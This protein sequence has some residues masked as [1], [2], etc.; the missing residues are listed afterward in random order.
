[1]YFNLILA[2]SLLPEQASEWAFKVDHVFLIVTIIC[3][4][5]FVLVEGALV[6]LVFKYRR[7][8]N[9]EDKKTPFITHNT[10]LEVI[11]AIIPTLVMFVLFYYGATT[12]YQM[13][14]MPKEYRQIDVT[15]RQWSWKF[16]YPNGVTTNTQS[17]CTNAEFKN[18]LDCEVKGFS[19]KAG[20]PLVVPINQKVVLRMRSKDVI[21]S[22]YV[23]AFRVKQDVVPGITSKLWFTANRIGT[24]DIFCAEYCGL[25][26]SGMI[27]K[28]IVKLADEYES[29]LVAAKE[30]QEK[31]AALAQNPEQMAALGKELFSIKKGCVACHRL[32][33]KRLVG[34]PLNG[35]FGKTRSFMD[36]STVTADENY[37]SESIMDPAAKIV[38]ES[39]P[40]PPM[41]AQD[42]NENEVKAIVEFLKGCRDINC[43]G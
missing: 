8:K 25:D 11:W 4:I 39:P 17:A 16:T 29:W 5:S 19:W 20:E 9:E 35:I 33:G 13:R 7:K 15:G 37:L 18:Q 42:V 43:G 22:F 3:A 34:P 1:M 14:T 26:H 41:N 40:Y 36:G 23:P 10:R 21:H 24:Y 2:L 6:F 31:M 12:Y 27:G 30:E 32:D 38:K 28:V